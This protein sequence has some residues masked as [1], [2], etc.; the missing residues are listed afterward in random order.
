VWTS[1][2]PRRRRGLTRTA[3]WPA[4]GS[5]R[6]SAR[7]AA[8]SEEG[9][10]AAVE[11]HR[12]WMRYRRHDRVR[13]ELGYRVR[14]GDRARSLRVI[15]ATRAASHVA[16]RAR[17]SR[18]SSTDA[19]S[20]PDLPSRGTAEAAKR[21]A[22]GGR[23]SPRA[24]CLRRRA[25]ATATRRVPRRRPRAPP[26]RRQV[27]G[28]GDPAL[29]SKLPCALV[30]LTAR[31]TGEDGI[32]APRA[33][34]QRVLLQGEMRSSSTGNAMPPARKLVAPGR[35]AL[36]PGLNPG[37]SFTESLQPR[38][39]LRRRLRLHS[40][41]R[42]RWRCV[43]RECAHVLGR[44]RPIGR[45]RARLPRRHRAPRRTPTSAPRVPLAAGRREDR[46]RRRAT[47]EQLMPTRQQRKRM[48]KERRNART[49]TVWSDF[50]GGTSS[51]SAGRRPDAH[52]AAP[53]R[54]D[55]P[56][57]APAQRSSR[58]TRT[59]IPSRGRR[60]ATSHSYS[61]AGTL[62]EFALLIRSKNGQ[63]QY[64]SRG[65]RRPLYRVFSPFTLRLDP[66]RLPSLAAEDGGSLR[67]VSGAIG[68]RASALSHAV[69]VTTLTYAQPYF[70][71]VMD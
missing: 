26:A 5:S 59:P 8:L 7:R 70:A 32:K 49:R 28:V 18:R 13:G 9:L 47:P 20:L 54:E 25:G 39:L 69:V 48:Q 36:S 41:R 21:S 65:P 15:F 27:H 52:T 68:A 55:A 29:R 53:G 31:P 35:T 42:R 24:R 56:E 62:R 3:R 23:R 63:H 44:C 16:R 2:R 40:P 64:G 33:A 4:A 50:R 46:R 57:E 71:V 11:R 17:P 66:L 6:P 14:Q 43:H 12:D 10:R 45:L 34:R 1:S 58:A 19:D 61:C 60:A 22:E 38:V 67:S 37:S 30:D 51:R